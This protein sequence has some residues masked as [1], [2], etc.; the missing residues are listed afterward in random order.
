MLV[1]ELRISAT[2]V[3]FKTAEGRVEMVARKHGLGPLERALL[4]VAD[5]RQDFAALLAA[6]GRPA[7]G[8]AESR[9]A[10]RRLIELELLALTP[11]T[12][13]PAPAE[14]KSLALARL[15][16]MESV[17]RALRGKTDALKPLLRDATDEAGLRRA[18]LACE[19][20]LLDAGAVSQA[21]AIRAR[22]LALLPGARSA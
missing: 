6:L 21:S 13:A 12:D 11:A 3:A 16:L 17:E 14:R 5:G 7:S 8:D 1:P 18:L 22:C 15:Y 9:T 10:L 19:K 20:A 4:I 2:D